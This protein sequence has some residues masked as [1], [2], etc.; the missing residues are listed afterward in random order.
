MSER[1]GYCPKCGR[2]GVCTW[3]CQREESV[4]AAEFRRDPSGTLQRATDRHDGLA[5]TDESGRIVGVL[6]VPTDFADGP[7]ESAELAAVRAWRA[8]G[9][10]TDVVEVDLLLRMVDELTDERE[11][12][13][14]LAK[15]IA[16]ERDELRAKLGKLKCLHSDMADLYSK[17]KAKVSDALTTVDCWRRLQEATSIRAGELDAKLAEAEKLRGCA[18]AQADLFAERWHEERDRAEAAEARVLSMR[19]ALRAGRDL[20]IEFLPDQKSTITMM[21]L[22]LSEKP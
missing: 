1:R 20:I 14:A 18:Y 2:A 16:K 9:W 15:G 4:T 11:L 10:A 21:G 17:E 5:I 19:D 8:N 22:A 3:D 6:S 13:V 7:G 12:K